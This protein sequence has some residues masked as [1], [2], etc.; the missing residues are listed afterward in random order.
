MAMTLICIS[1]SS[2]SSG[3]C[4]TRGAGCGRVSSEG[5]VDQGGNPGSSEV[6]RAAAGLIAAEIEVHA[7]KRRKDF[8][9]TLP[10]RGAAALRC[11]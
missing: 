1:S 2:V 9:Q 5:T 4:V 11:L 8:N 7:S 10:A 3:H 6:N